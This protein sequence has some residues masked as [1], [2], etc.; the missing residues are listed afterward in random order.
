MNTEDLFQ[1]IN[2]ASKLLCEYQSRV[3][4]IIKLIRDSSNFKKLEKGEGEGWNRFN[5]YT[6]YPVNKFD[7]ING[8]EY[9]IMETQLNNDGWIRMEVLHLMNQTSSENNL[10]SPI[11]IFMFT[12]QREGL[13]GWPSWVNPQDNEWIWTSIK[14]MKYIWTASQIMNGPKDSIFIAL[15]ISMSE[16]MNKAD[17]YRSLDNIQEKLK[18]IV[19]SVCDFKLPQLFDKL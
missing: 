5:Y 10:S 3:L 4:S 1:Q 15:P 12:Y 17:I 8:Y 18:E 16:L 7:W 6:S 14:E 9:P 11:L 19:L 13:N 2:V